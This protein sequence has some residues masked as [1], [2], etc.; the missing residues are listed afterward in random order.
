MAEAIIAVAFARSRHATW[1]EWHVRMAVASDAIVVAARW[2]TV[3][4]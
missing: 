3:D 1:W 4:L 2:R